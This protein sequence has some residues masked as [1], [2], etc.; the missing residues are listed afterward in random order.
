MPGLVS[1]GPALTTLG[2]ELTSHAKIGKRVQRRIGCQV[3]A[4]AMTAVTAIR[5]ATFYV[6]LTAKTQATVTTVAR[7]YPDCCFVDEF[8]FR[9]LVNNHSNTKNPA[10]A[11]LFKNTM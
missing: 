2:L 5:A 3:Y 9:I 6:F 10:E 11:G 1:T 8:H 7:E 4:A